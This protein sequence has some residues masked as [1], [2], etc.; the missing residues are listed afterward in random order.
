MGNEST[1]QALRWSQRC[2]AEAVAQIQRCEIEET[3]TRALHQLRL[4]IEHLHRAVS[5]LAAQEAKEAKDEDRT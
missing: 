4:A 1:A 5:E 3:S 2:L